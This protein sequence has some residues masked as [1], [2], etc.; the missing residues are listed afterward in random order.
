[1]PIFYKESNDPDK[2]P[3]IVAADEAEAIAYYG[4]GNYRAETD[5]FDTWFS[6]GQWAYA[7]LMATGDFDKGFFPTSVMMTAR[8]ILTKWVTRMAMFSFY[9]T[10]SVP[11]KDVYLWGL[12]N[13]EHGKKMSKSKGNVLNPLDLTDKFGTDALRLALTIGI[14]PGND[15]VLSER[16]IE[17]YR[18]FCNKLWNVGRFILGQLPEGYSPAVP[19]A[20]SPADHWIMA[21]IDQVIEDVTASIEDYRFSEAG[22]TVY[23]LLWDDFADWYVEA[24]KVDPNYDVLIYGLETILKLVHPI[25]PFVSEAIWSHLDW[26][27]DMLIVTPWPMRTK[28]EINAGSVKIFE[29]AQEVVAKVRALAAEEQLSKPTV[30][31]TDAGLAAAADLV[32]RLAKA[33]ELKLVEEGSGFYLGSVA[34]AWIS[35]T[36][37]QVAARRNRLEA[38]R[39]EKGKYASSL[40]AKLSN[41]RFVANAPEAVIVEVRGKLSEAKELLSR[42]EEQLKAL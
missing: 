38:Q 7:T 3:Y 9:T 41:E 2:T 21:K 42:L 40:E 4:E 30:V 33:G 27:K 10:G 22:Q 11:F 31:T 25:A 29:Q 1:M 19:V 13:D 34:P 18:N 5:V 20:K 36:A 28:A 32:C 15:G 17:G 14:T 35:A 12:V 8:D 24:S 26:N 39:E 16:K 23:S 6:S 37:E